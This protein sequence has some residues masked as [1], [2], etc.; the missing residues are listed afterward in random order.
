MTTESL[1]V[2]QTNALRKQ[3]GLPP[4]TTAPPP[5]ASPAPPTASPSDDSVAPSIST[6]RAELARRQQARQAAALLSTASLSQQLAFS[7][8]GSAASWV[9]RHRVVMEEEQKR[10]AARQREEDERKARDKA[11]YDA[12]Q[13]RGLRVV[14]DYDAFEDDGERVLVLKDKRI[15]DADGADDELVDTDLDER[16]RR[17]QLKAGA[18]KKSWEDDFERPSLL[19]KY[20]EEEDK[21]EGLVLGGGGQYSRDEDERRRRG[22]EEE[23]RRE[24]LQ[25]VWGDDAPA[26]K[27]YDVSV[28]DRRVDSDYREVTFRKKKDR[29]SA[30]SDDA[31]GKSRSHRQKKATEEKAA[32]DWISQLEDEAKKQAPADP[33]TREDGSR[34]QRE[35]AERKERRTQGFLRALEKGEEETRR[36]LE[37]DREEERVHAAPTREVEEE[38]EELALAVERARRITQ[39]EKQAT[40][41]KV[42]VEGQEEGREVRIGGVERTSGIKALAERIASERGDGGVKREGAKVEGFEAMEAGDDRDEEEGL[43]FTSVSNFASGLTAAEE[44]GRSRR[45]REEREKD[46]KLPLSRPPG[47]KLEQGSG[48]SAAT[49]NGAAHGSAAHSAWSMHDDNADVA[50]NGAEGYVKREDD[51]DEDGADDDGEDDVVDSGDDILGDEPLAS[52]GMA[53][54]LALAQRRAYL[55]SSSSPAAPSSSSSSSE[56]RFNLAQY[57]ALGR[58]LSAKEKFRLLSHAFHGQGAGINKRDKRVRSM[59]REVGVLKRVRDKEGP[60]GGT[61]KVLDAQRRLGQAYLV[62]DSTKP[63]GSM[64]SMLAP[65]PLSAAAGARSSGTESDSRKRVKR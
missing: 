33:S 31:A 24:G 4:L 20:D 45:E 13:L 35:D 9:E 62:L 29:R 63:L 19:G 5:A 7:T 32:D 28:V 61:Q 6:L 49:T 40:V 55:T 30:A 65:S 38:D 64:G 37:R 36:R 8:A 39:R 1:T 41:I 25:Q 10:R 42:K 44:S 2:E 26:R 51:E 18:K 57:D 43:V 23:E 22:R 53:G 50:E 11:Q 60:E 54:A 59:K 12:E 46:T 3:M 14:H 56:P 47:M 15:G 17:A 48:A 58:E 16:E 34:V 21:R 52:V 27:E